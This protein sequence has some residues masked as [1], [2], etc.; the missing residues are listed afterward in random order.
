MSFIKKYFPGVMLFL[1]FL[2]IGLMHYKDYGLGWDE[3]IHRIIGNVTYDYIFKGDM[4]LKTIEFRNLGTGFEL[5]LIFM[6][7]CLHLTDFRDI[8][9]MRHLATHIFFLFGAFS[10]YVLAFRHFN[11]RSIAS[12]A[13]LMLVLN[14]RL[15]AHS[16][17]NSKD[18]PFLVSFILAFTVWHA[19]D[20]K[21]KKYL[22]LLVGAACGY[23]TS[24]RV[25]GVLLVP[26]F[27]F[28]VAFDLFRYMKNK[29]ELKA[30]LMKLLLFSAGFCVTLYI[31]W[32]ILWSNPIFYFHEQFSSL[33][34]VHWEGEVYFKG[35]NIPG[36]KLPL[37]Y[38][39]VWMS[40]TI[41]EVWLIG[42]IAGCVAVAVTFLRKPVSFLAD[43]ANRNFALYLACFAGP[44]LV[45]VALGS[46]NYDD[47]RHLYFTYPPLMLLGLFLI[48]KLYNTS[49]R[50]FV[51]I[52]CVGQ[53]ALTTVFIVNNHP[54]QYAYFNNLV[55]HKDQYLLN[56]YDL[57][58][59]GVTYSEGV[60]Y[61]L[62]HD[63]SDTIRINGTTMLLGN[64][65]M[66]MTP[67]DR[68]R[69]KIVDKGDHP[70]YFITN[71]RNNHPEDYQY[72]TIF[73]EVKVLNSTIMRVYKVN[74]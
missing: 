62:D 66:K 3:P 45:V 27:L 10:L 52:L 1:I 73:Y 6:E 57:D 60:K 22:Y 36:S 41:P 16:F 39:P 13:F 12:L 8:Y 63:K 64:A 37:S 50:I 21:Q 72:P 47:W 24:I 67:A 43:M 14:P 49:T 23:A 74:K 71:F 35:Q 51:Y 46:V 56:N 32:P 18:I 65:S 38:L 29:S 44:L 30:V 68:Q 11:H 53:L 33:A 5:P 58:Y 69:I 61:I 20:T 25:M 2:V 59:W 48:N 17:F 19:A 40:M 54:H 28:F 70:D 26:C 4:N 55:S 31:C 7:K 42:G 15:Y 9:L 34:H